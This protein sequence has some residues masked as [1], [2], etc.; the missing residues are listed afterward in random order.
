MFTPAQLA[1]VRLISRFDGE[2][3]PY[4]IEAEMVHSGLPEDEWTPIHDHLELLENAGVI[5]QEARAARHMEVSRNRPWKTRGVSIARPP[6][7]P[8]SG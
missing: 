1:I 7:F 3:G 8:C 5:R 4:S 2:L 6:S